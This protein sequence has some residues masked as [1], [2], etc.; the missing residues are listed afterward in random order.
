M[1]KKGIRYAVFATRT[2]TTSGSTVTVSYTGGKTLSP[3]AAYNGTV[4]KT[5]AKD[6][7]D[8][9]VVDVDKVVTGGTL[10]VELNNDED[11]IYTM[12][13][14]HTKS[15]NEIEYKDSDQAPFVGTGA[16]GQSGA[17]WK[18]RWYPKVQFSEPNDENTTRQENVTFGHVTLE[19]EILIPNDGGDD[20][21]LWKVTEV[22]DTFTAAKTWLDGKAGIS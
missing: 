11:E 17:K 22:F 6:Y 13:L 16:I 4:N 15:T 21:G 7:G 2:V 9:V 10:S 18:A 12:L 14:G 1:A 8:D 20:D 19:G 5:D 3:V